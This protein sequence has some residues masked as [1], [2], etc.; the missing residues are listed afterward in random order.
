[1]MFSG[2]NRACLLML[3]AVLASCG[4]GGGGGG[5]AAVSSPGGGGIGGTGLTSSGTVD[6]FGSIFVNGVEFETDD[7]VILVDGESVG[8]DQLGLGMVVVVSGTVNDDGATG[9]AE[10][11]IYDEEVEGPVE[12]IERDQDG[13]SMLLV[14]VGQEVI[15]ERT[16]TV[17]DDVSFDTLTAGHAY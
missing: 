1:M 3:I 13:D 9:I 6:G 7:A 11:V 14:V 17:F 16:G 5:V 10:R 12:S 8:E 15:A 2:I 4:G